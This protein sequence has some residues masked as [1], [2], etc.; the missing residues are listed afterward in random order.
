MSKQCFILFAQH[1][2]QIQGKLTNLGAFAPFEV[3][4]PKKDVRSGCPQDLHHGDS[5]SCSHC[6]MD[7][8]AGLTSPGW[9]D[10]FRPVPPARRDAVRVATSIICFS[11][12]PQPLARLSVGILAAH[13]GRCSVLLGTAFQLPVQPYP[14]PLLCFVLL[15]AMSCGCACS[16]PLQQ[17]R[18]AAGALSQ[19]GSSGCPQFL[20]PQCQYFYLDC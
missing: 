2:K 12:R 1:W 15:P 17:C 18:W 3:G 7:A 9:G 13:A 8:L 19:L 20:V 4:N 5:E 16:S 14:W 11:S 10:I 6:S